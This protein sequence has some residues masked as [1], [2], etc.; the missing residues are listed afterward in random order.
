M[1]GYSLTDTN[2]FFI[3]LKTAYVSLKKVSIE[4]NIHFEDIS[5]FHFHTLDIE[6]L[7]YLIFLRPTL[8]STL[9]TR[10]ENHD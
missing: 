3:T 7:I 8:L 9:L 10:N 2:P 6:N 1:H 4:I 5:A